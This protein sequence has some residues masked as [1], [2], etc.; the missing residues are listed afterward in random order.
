MRSSQSPEWQRLEGQKPQGVVPPIQLSS[1]KLSKIGISTLIK[2]AARVSP[3]TATD[4][5]PQRRYAKRMRRI[6]QQTQELVELG[7]I[8]TRNTHLDL[9][10]SPRPSRVTTAEFWGEKARL[11][12]IQ[13]L[14]FTEAYRDLETRKAVQRSDGT[15]L[16]LSANSTPRH[17]TSVSALRRSCPTS[18][19]FSESLPR[20]TKLPSSQFPNRIGS[21]HKIIDDCDQLLIDN[22]KSRH[23][24]TS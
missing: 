13:Q 17:H 20:L 11:K 18:P 22:G 10:S 12:L 7:L 1:L 6:K 4:S 15:H 16:R 14:G 8:S 3:T 19:T 2:P 9:E 24:P 5:Q 23:A 21:I